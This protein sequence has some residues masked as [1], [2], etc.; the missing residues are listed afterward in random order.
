[1]GLSLKELQEN[2]RNQFIKKYEE[3]FGVKP[4]LKPYMTDDEK[5]MSGDYKL[6]INIYGIK[7]K[8]M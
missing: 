5:L 8:W 6:S 7:S 3:T 1:M 4:E 2:R